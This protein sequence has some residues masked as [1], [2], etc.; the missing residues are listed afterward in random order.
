[1]AARKT[2][3][4]K[5][6]AILFAV[7]MAVMLASTIAATA[8][9]YTSYEQE[10]ETF[11]LS[12][13]S[14]YASAINSLTDQEAIA[15]L[16]ND[17]FVD[18][19]CTLVAKDGEVLF[20][21]YA[22]AKTLGNHNDRQEVIEARQSGTVTVMRRSDTLESFTLYAA[23]ATDTGL[24]LRLSET[25]TSL[26]SFIG[27]MW[28]RLAIFMVCIFAI[29]FGVSR[30]L[31]RMIMDP[32]TKIDLSHPLDNDVYQEIKPLLVR[33]EEQHAELSKQNEELKRA[34]DMRREFTGNVSHEMKTPLQ[35]ISG[36]AELIENGMVAPEDI[37]RFAGL[38]RNEAMTLK[39]TVD[40]VLTLS[41]L[42]ESAQAAA[43]PVCLA[44]VCKRVTARL[45]Q[46]AAQRDVTFCTS[47]DNDIFAF[48]DESLIDQTV[49]N[50][51]SNAVKY[52][53]E[54]GVVFIEVGADQDNALISVADE[55]CGIPPELRERVFER[56][57]RVDP[58]R[59]R[60]TGGTGLGLAIVKHAVEQLGGTVGIEDGLCG[61]TKFVVTLPLA[62]SGGADCRI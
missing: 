32:L 7:S 39:V 19:R 36:Y 46:T 51:V 34:V 40:D 15:Y 14:T 18:T 24:V 9:S 37:S 17:S 26:A 59:S 30:L 48:G 12:Q 35:V 21:S 42:D 4:G 50:L 16:E 52:N 58:S 28:W 54:G 60:A 53:K 20:D 13:T 5:I 43:R 41:R 38:I 55:G 31:A 62:H 57:Y 10:A 47:Y 3:S 23:A 49:N 1:M 25:R 22:D 33:V 11:L 2:L 8:A 27:G 6:F 56:F 29:S 44:E 61:G 45:E